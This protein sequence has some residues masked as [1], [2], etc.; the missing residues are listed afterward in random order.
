MFPIEKLPAIQANPQDFRLLTKLP[1]LTRPFNVRES[2][3]EQEQPLL[4]VDVE[5][6]GLDHQKD[7]VIEIGLCLCSYL[8]GEEHIT[9][10]IKSASFYNDPGS[11]IP[12]LITKLT[13]ITDEMVR[14][15]RID[16]EDHLS[17]YFAGRPL[18]VAHNAPF[19][20]PFVEPFLP[21][22]KHNLPWACSCNEVDWTELGHEGTKLYYLGVDH[23]FFYDAH[24]AQYDCE[25]VAWM[26]AKN[27]K[28]FRQLLCRALSPSVTVEAVR[29]PYNVKDD[30]KAAGYRWNGSVWSKAVPEYEEGAELKF[31]DALPGYDSRRARLTRQD[32]T[33]RF[34]AG[35]L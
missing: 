3:P 19:D 10:I 31:L 15:H 30:L 6:T 8:P 16:W 25:A 29:A 2:F 35:S 11:P 12:P 1:E 4:I 28:A 33:E 14:C 13:G 23:G 32:A 21:S 20:R 34:K 26:L 7:S 18:V 27:K 22:D 17:E 9:R 24:R 5:T